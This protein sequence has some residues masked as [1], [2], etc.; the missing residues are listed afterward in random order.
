MPLLF[1]HD[2]GDDVNDLRRHPIYSV[3][4]DIAHVTADTNFQATKTKNELTQLVGSFGDEPTVLIGHGVGG[5]WAHWLSAE[6]NLPAVLINPVVSPALYLRQ[7]VGRTFYNRVWNYTDCADYFNIVPDVVKNMMTVLVSQN[8]E[9]FPYMPVEEKYSGYANVV[10][11]AKAG[12][13]FNDFDLFKY[14]LD[15]M[16]GNQIEYKIVA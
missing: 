2:F 14:E 6:F 1:L 4:P 15:K 11:A 8:D 5:F 3:F 9:K 13:K 16:V 10:L 12:H 7:F